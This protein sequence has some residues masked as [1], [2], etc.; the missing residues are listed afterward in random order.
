MQHHPEVTF[1]RMLRDTN[2][3]KKLFTPIKN[4]SINPHL[5]YH[6]IVRQ[7]WGCLACSLVRM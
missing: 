7:G 4:A 5:F 2:R 1:E 3:L 6:F